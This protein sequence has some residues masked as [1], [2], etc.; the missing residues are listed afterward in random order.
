MKPERCLRDVANNAGGDLV[1]LRLPA[2]HMPNGGCGAP[3]HVVGTNGGTM[4]CG[5][6][7][8]QLDGSKAPYYCP[9]CEQVLRSGVTSHRQ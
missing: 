5:A 9:H 7:L 3:T 1:E 6:V 4:P 2:L 8:H